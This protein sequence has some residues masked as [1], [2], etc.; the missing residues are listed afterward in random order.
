MS[1]FRT[2][3]FV[4]VIKQFKGN[5]EISKSLREKKHSDYLAAKDAMPKVIAAL[6]KTSR[7]LYEA[8]SFSQPES[9][10]HPSAPEHKG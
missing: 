1:A 7:V 4:N 5:T 8:K 9:P 10:L 6:E 3:D 2:V